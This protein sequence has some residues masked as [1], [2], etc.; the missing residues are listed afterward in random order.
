MLN[1]EEFSRE[2]H[3]LLQVSLME[4]MPLL[5]QQIAELI[6]RTKT[7]MDNMEFLK[8]LSFGEI[9]TRHESIPEAHAKTFEWV[10]KNR[11]PDGLH[12]IHFTEWLRGGRGIYWVRGKPGLG[13]STL[14]KFLRQHKATRVNLLQWSL[15]QKLITCNHFFW[16]AGSTLQ[17]S[18]EGLF[19][20][21]LFN[22]LLQCPEIIPEVQQ[23]QLS[24]NTTDPYNPWSSTSLYR[25]I[26]FVIS[27]GL[28]VRFCFF[29]DGLDKYEGDHVKLIDVL[30][31]LASSPNI[32]IC[33]SSR[34]W[35][36][37]LE[38]FGN[39]AQASLKL[40]ELT[41]SD[42]RRYVDDR[43]GGN[44]QFQRNRNNNAEY[45]ALVTEVVSRANGVFLWVSL[46]VKSLLEGITYSDRIVDLRRRLETLPTD[47][48]DF[49]SHI[50]RSVDSFYWQQSAQIFLFA[51][52]ASEEL[53]VILYS[54]ADEID[55]D[56]SRIVE[57]RNDLTLQKIENGVEEMIRRLDGRTKGLLEVSY[58]SQAG[59]LHARY[60]VGFLHRTVRNW[61]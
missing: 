40:E 9:R 28:P 14:M 12:D 38:A 19:R 49:F 60:K 47:L 35:A 55:G 24:D 1:S 18:Q 16:N 36:C 43:L 56:A 10:F 41:A 59:R 50:L 11:T 29:I 25:A 8:K 26:E 3:R 6:P 58:V 53:P 2:R 61:L 34:P 44:S 32:K 4:H 51:I 20:T 42:I 31:M 48:E 30:Q 22:I 21:L 17:N 15:E 33:T 57:V 52:K 5:S 39:N 45:L 46:V 54:I 37:F 23:Q 27:R 7:A 13:K